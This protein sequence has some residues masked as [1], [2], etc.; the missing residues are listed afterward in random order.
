MLVGEK[1]AGNR[2]LLLE[3]VTG[4][5]MFWQIGPCLAKRGEPVPKWMWKAARPRT[6]ARMRAILMSEIALSLSCE[7]SGQIDQV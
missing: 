6:I 4:I 2:A 3:M 1:S 7:T 5:V